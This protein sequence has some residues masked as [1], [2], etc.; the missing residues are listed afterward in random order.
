MKVCIW[1]NTT[2]SGIGDRLQDILLVL[3]Y[4]R[5]HKCDKLLMKWKTIKQSVGKRPKYRDIDQKVDVMK[6][7]IKFPSDLV[8][9]D[10]FSSKEYK[11]KIK[12][13]NYIGGI[14]SKK[15]FISKYKLKEDIYSKIYND[16]VNDFEFISNDLFK[17]VDESENL[18]VIHL[19][20]A[21]KILSKKGDAGAALG[22]TDKELKELNNKTKVII[23]K[24]IEKG[25]KNIAFVSDSEEE[26]KNY[27][28]IYKNKLS[29]LE[30]NGNLS[31]GEQT[32]I[33]LYT[34]TKADTI[35]MSQKYSNFSMVASILGSN[36]L[37]Y[38]DKQ[39]IDKYQ[40]NSKQYIYH[41]DV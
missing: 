12:F 1:E 35:V 37:L 22:I 32:Y 41:L 33:D 23:D 27:I 39:Y 21:D 30:V 29:I 20:R 5:Y 11:S 36:K 7:Y 17:K 40:Y 26:K 16:V 31:S 3:S 28:S 2:K 13:S 14:H 9:T 15:T 8:I 10:N 25:Y 24:Y 4:S 18:L 38:F 34:L 19:R 6:K